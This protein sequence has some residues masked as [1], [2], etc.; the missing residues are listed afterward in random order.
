M[1]FLDLLTA[2]EIDSEDTLRRFGNN[3]AILE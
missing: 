3:Q 2:L 1:T